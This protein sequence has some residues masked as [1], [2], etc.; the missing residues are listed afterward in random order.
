MSTRIILS[1]RGVLDRLTGTSHSEQRM[2]IAR[3]RLC[4]P[5][6]SSYSQKA[7]IALYKNRTPFDYRNLEEPQANDELG[8]LWPMRRFPV[9]VD[10]DRVVIEVTCVIEYLDLHYPGPVKLIP[11]APDSAIEVRMLDRFFDNYIPRRSR[12]SSSTGC[13][14][15]RPRPLRHRTSP[16][17]ARHRVR[18]T[19]PAHGDAR[20]GYRHGLLAGRLRR[21]ALS[22]PCR[23]DPPDRHAL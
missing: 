19:G 15:S 12:K 13:V 1:N 23:L 4:A 9:L 3:P 17:H 21:R 5:P 20:M 14:P 7:L 22:L 10:G 2:P 16:R 8:E 18:V 11:A 6:F